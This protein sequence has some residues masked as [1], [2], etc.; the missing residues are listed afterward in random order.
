MRF[1]KRKRATKDAFVTRTTSLEQR[2]NETRSVKIFFFFSL[3]HI[4]LFQKK[5]G[6]KSAIHSLSRLFSQEYRSENGD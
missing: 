4:T 6:K 3:L 1:L 2:R 5:K